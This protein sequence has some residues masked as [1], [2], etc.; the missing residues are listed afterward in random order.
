[1]AKASGAT[2][3]TTRALSRKL[4]DGKPIHDVELVGPGRTAGVERLYDQPIS[5]IMDNLQNFAAGLNTNQDKRSHTFYNFPLTLTRVELENMFRS[6]W[7]AKRIVRTPADDMFRAGWELTWDG[8]DDD[9]AGAKAVATAVKNVQLKSK[10]NESMSWGRLYGRCSIVIDIKGQEDWSQPLDLAKVGKDS[11]RSLHVLDRWRLSPTGELDYDRT[12][13]NYGRPNFYTISD[14]GDPRY[15]VHWSRVVSF[16]GEPLPWF[17]YTQN[18]YSEDS[19]LQHIAETI[20]DYDATLAGVA[21]MVYEANVD[22]LTTPKLNAA[23]A[24]DKG[25]ANLV[26]RYGIAAMMKSFNH[27]MILDGGDGTKESVG[28][29]W[30]QKVAQFSGLKDV[31]EKFMINVCGAADIPMTRL[32]GQS[33]A[34]LTATGESDIRNYYDRI[35]ADQEAKIRPGLEKLF[36]VLIRSTL[37]HMPDDF[38]L[39]FKPLWQLSDKEKAEV[40]YLQAQTSQIYLLQG[41]IPE[42][43]VT[44]RLVELKT[45]GNS[46]TAADVDLVKK[47][48]QQAAQLPD[49]GKLGQVQPGGVKAPKAGRPPAA[50]GNAEPDTGKK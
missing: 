39:E 15:R 30:Q 32:F 40:E 18:A 26:K 16:S 34:G 41:V 20:R 14:I 21:S 2:P 19:V 47:L 36:E 31:I 48:E 46:L 27:M 22:I 24:S 28:E 11:L 50:A 17:L 23:L 44:A 9:K 35:S 37:G 45:Y 12:S 29:T 10:A 33:P 6:S 38:A 13:T 42:H 7:L 3:P 4:A 25:Q 8:Y 43:A 1:M 49:P 5:R